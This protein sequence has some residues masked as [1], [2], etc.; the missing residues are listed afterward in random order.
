MKHQDYVEGD[1]LCSCDCEGKAD[2]DG[3]EYHAE[4]K[5]AYCCHLRSVV[6]D[7]V[8]RF[9]EF[10]D[11]CFLG[12]MAIVI[13][14]IDVLSGVGE[15]IFAWGVTL[16]VGRGAA[17]VFEAV[18]VGFLVVVMGV[19]E[20]GECSEAHGHQLYEE[21]HKDC[22]EG[23]A[24]SPVVVCCRAREARVCESI[25]GGS[26]EVDK[27][28]GYYDAGA[29]VFCSEECP[30]WDS[31]ASMSAGVDR[32]CGTCT[33]QRCGGKR[34]GG[35]L[36]RIPNSEPTSMTKMAETRRPIL[37]SYSLSEVQAGFAVN[38]IA[39]ADSAAAD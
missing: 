33:C 16:A 9:V 15:V 27:C 20:R 18:M 6:F 28:S 3:V 23:Y 12:G 25:T 22:H 39:A 14:V 10:M 4:F 5:D 2:E 36:L 24:F 34:A 21:E 38:V 17:G 30:F 19:S 35:R 8:Q 37:P 32:K 11:G 26:E 31:Y 13:V 1:E 7:F 29:K